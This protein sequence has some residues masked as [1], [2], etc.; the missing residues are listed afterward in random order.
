M[1]AGRAA[2]DIAAGK[3]YFRTLFDLI[4]TAH[5]AGVPFLAGTDAPAP[6]VFPGSSL[7]EEL[8]LLVE[9]GLTPMEALQTATRNPAL[10]L[11]QQ[12]QIGTIEVG[13]IA[14]LILLEANP[15]EDIANTQK[16]AAV[17]VGGKLFSRSA[18]QALRTAAATSAQQE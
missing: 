7:Y 17:V 12:D 18:L 4:K 8:A 6:Y 16:I 15:L 1:L 14:D 11:D 13:K 9:A 2:E 10:Y 3:Q 5:G